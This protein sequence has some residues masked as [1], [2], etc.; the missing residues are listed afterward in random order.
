[1]SSA[2]K[3]VCAFFVVAMGRSHALDLP[4]LD[5]STTI[6]APPL[7]H[8]R[9]GDFSLLRV[10]SENGLSARTWLKFDLG[11]VP[12][13]ITGA[14][15]VQ[16]KLRLWVSARTTTAGATSRIRIAA[17]QAAWDE[18]S[19]NHANAPAIGPTTLPDLE[20]ADKLEFVVGD[21][22]ALVRAWV[23][24][25]KPNHGICLVPAGAGTAMNV[26]FDSKESITSAHEAVLELSFAGPP[27]AKGDQ[28][29]NGEPGLAGIRGE[30]GPDGSPGQK[31]DGGE[32]GEKGDP[33][34]K[35]DRGEVGPPGP[36]ATRVPPR[37]DIPMGEFVSGRK[38]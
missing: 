13:G 21:L 37:G 33:G 12:S 38:P 24:G 17:V 1:M 10:A 22:T 4:L 32:K 8:I 16:A 25:T 18:L 27:G 29:D 26:S 19:L 7:A 36:P 5:D 31:G 3:L 34:E 30:R 35:G 20:I 28:G 23:D 2:F 15:I 9:F 6:N 14:Q 11:T